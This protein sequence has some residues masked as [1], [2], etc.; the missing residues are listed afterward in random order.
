MLINA[1][2]LIALEAGCQQQ[3][4]P[5]ALLGLSGSLF[6]ES[7]V[8]ITDAPSNETSSSQGN[9]HKT[10]AVGTIVGIAIAAALLVLVG[11]TLFLVYWRR[12]RRFDRED[13]I[14]RGGRDDMYR[15]YT[16]ASSITTAGNRGPYLSEDPKDALFASQVVV[17]NGMYSKP[18]TTFQCHQQPGVYDGP[19][20]YTASDSAIP[21]HPAY[22][23]RALMRKKSTATVSTTTQVPPN[24]VYTPS[25]I[26]GQPPTPPTAPDASSSSTHS[27]DPR[28]RFHPAQVSLP[29]SHEASPMP[30]PP[31]LTPPEPPLP[32][33]NMPLRQQRKRY[34][35]PR[36]GGGTPIPG[37][38][39]MAITGPLAF[40]E[41][42]QQQV[43]VGDESAGGLR[44]FRE[45]STSSPAV[46]GRRRSGR[47]STLFNLFG[48]G[49]DDRNAEQ[50]AVKKRYEEVPL[51]GGESDLYG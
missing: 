13:E 34:S 29:P 8:N 25:T 16:G 48:G 35:P 39:D 27:P 2:V 18:G 47:A 10:L 11:A 12:Q 17:N 3:P 37:R 7:A 6:T 30:S 31:L 5:G 44:S 41:Q 40:P 20:G 15:P 28:T 22:I 38:E 24:P 21:A 51:R 36:L 4:V 45:R 42:H 43:W 49:G 14:R 23:P 26:G 19:P 46:A 33:A 32:L 9:T 50:A 1:L